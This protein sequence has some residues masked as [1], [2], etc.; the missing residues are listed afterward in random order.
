MKLLLQ[1]RVEDDMKDFTSSYFDFLNYSSFC[2]LCDN[3]KGAH[4]TCN[5]AFRKRAKAK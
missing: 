4:Y 2:D 1:V 5:L 3:L